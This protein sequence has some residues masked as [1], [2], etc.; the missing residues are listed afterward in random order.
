MD[1]NGVILLVDDDQDDIE[2]L[3]QIF[4]EVGNKH[5]LV[6]YSMLEEAFAYLKSHSEKPFLIICDNDYRNKNKDKLGNLIHNY[7]DFKLKGIPFVFFSSVVEKD[8]INEAYTDLNVQ[9]FFQKRASV[10]RL[11][12]DLKVILDYW[13]T[14]IHPQ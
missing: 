11:R 14:S 1:A 13:E 3:T 2:I 10:E 4:N 12:H 8:F 9:G 5:E 7:P 6:N